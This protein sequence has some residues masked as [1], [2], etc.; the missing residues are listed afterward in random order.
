MAY[1]QNSEDLERRIKEEALLAEK[2]F[3]E[4]GKVI[5]GQQNI[6]RRLLMAMIAQGHV[7]LEGLP[8]LAKTTA[9]KTLAKVS[10][11][12]FSRIQFTPDL[13]P[14]DVV[15]TQV[16]DPKTTDF[17][18]KKGP[19]FANLILADEINR[20]PAKVQA[21][22]LES[23]E[24]R[25]VTI[26]EKTWTLDE[27]FLVMATQNPVEQ[28]GTYPLPE[29]QLDRFLFKLKTCY[30]TMDEEQ[31]I[32]QRA[33]AKTPVALEKIADRSDLQ[34]MRDLVGDIYVSEKI[35]RYIVELVF[36]T[37]EPA[38]R[39]L[40]ELENLIEFG[41][42]PRASIALDRVARV[43]A[44][45]DGRTFVTPQDVKDVGIDV[46]R[47]RIKPTYEAEAEEISSEQI[48]TRVFESVDVP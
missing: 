22:L 25:Q 16:Y 43:N 32:I 18:V 3:S 24:E 33:A 2:I 28:E 27:P 35:H 7:L 9:I 44:L 8:G 5:V 4:L 21:A 46:L 36:A 48:I 31:E 47:H 15:G 26:G 1:D 20:A 13:L 17:K 10:D 11:L 12:S 29:A 39:G 6:S 37:R 42:S 34:R 41:A 19:I 14:A 30:G 23:M 40:K 45:I 38:S